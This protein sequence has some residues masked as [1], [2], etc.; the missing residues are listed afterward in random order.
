MTGTSTANVVSSNG[1]N[2]RL[3]PPEDLHAGHTTNPRLC[4]IFQ[5]GV[6]LYRLLENGGW[7]FDN[8]FEYSTSGVGLTPFS[9]PATD[10][11]TEVLREAALRMMEVRP[12]NRPD[13]V[14]KVKHELQTLLA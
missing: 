7:P 12:E 6:L 3:I 2:P 14:S 8:T 1:R 10:R 13:L 5:T 9:K 11:E 4:D